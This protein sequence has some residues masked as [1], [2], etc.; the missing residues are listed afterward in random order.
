MLNT[1][2]YTPFAREFCLLH[3][4]CFVDRRTLLARLRQG[5]GSAV[6]LIV[7][8][9]AEAVYA[10]VRWQPIRH[11]RAHKCMELQAYWGPESGLGCSGE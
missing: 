8:G 10:E 1:I 2:L 6:A 9:A 3:G 5:P 11:G 4:W 7:G